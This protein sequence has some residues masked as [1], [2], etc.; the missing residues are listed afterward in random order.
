VVRLPIERFPT[1]V[2]RG[3]W[4]PV[5]GQLYA[6]GMF[7]WA[8][9]QQEDGGFYRVRLTGRPLNVP[10]ELRARQ[11]AF[12]ITFTDPLDPLTARAPGSY[13]IRA[14]DLLR[15]KNYGSRHLNERPLRVTGAAL[16]AD[17]RTVTLTIPELAPSR[18]MEILC[19]L[20]SADGTE[21]ERRI[22]NTIHALAEP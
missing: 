9:N 20:R 17:G 18:G 13:S 2:M 1:G 8:G 5:N 14:W 19:R 21:F 6:A 10:I 11:G 15:S 12:S 16:S 22:H 7:A 3:R 4:H